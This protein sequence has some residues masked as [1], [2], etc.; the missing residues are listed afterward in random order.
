MLRP[1]PAVLSATLLLITVGV[2]PAR[3][4]EPGPLPAPD[5]TGGGSLMQALV[6]RQSHR[7]FAA[8]PLSTQQL[9]DL[10]WA[11]AGVNRPDSGKRT[12][13]SALNWQETDIYVVKADGVWRSTST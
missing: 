3:A 11:T 12:A 13:P 4:G 10:L 9:A 7:E 2:L 6:E 1:A 5:R 8:T